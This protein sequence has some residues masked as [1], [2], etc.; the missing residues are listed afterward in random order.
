MSGCRFPRFCLKGR[1]QRGGVARSNRP[2]WHRRGVILAAV[3]VVLLVVSLL[4]ATLIP[5]L[6]QAR[7]QARVWQWQQQSR[8]LAES[9]I[10]RAR[11]RLELDAAY[12]GE[13][14]R[15]PAHCFSDASAVGTGSSDG[16]EIQIQVAPMEGQPRQVSIAVKAQYPLDSIQCVTTE[17]ADVFPRDREESRR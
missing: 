11:L 14:W 1:L 3:L 8:L 7:R 12:A 6:S 5:E 10:E 13:T 16:A 4:V 15:V 17:L 2:V 9:A